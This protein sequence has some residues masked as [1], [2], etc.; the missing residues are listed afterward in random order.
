[1]WTL[2][3][4]TTLHILSVISCVRL[5]TTQLWINT[6]HLK[7][8]TQVYLF[9]WESTTVHPSKKIEQAIKKLVNL[10][11]QYLPQNARTYFARL[12]KNAGSYTQSFTVI[13]MTNFWICFYV[14]CDVSL[15][16]TGP[17]LL[18]NVFYSEHICSY[19]LWQPIGL[20]TPNQISLDAVRVVL[21]WARSH[22]GQLS[23]H[24]S[25]GIQ[26]SLCGSYDGWCRKHSNG[27][28][29]CHSTSAGH[30]WDFTVF[31]LVDCVAPQKG[32]N[33]MVHLPWWR[34]IL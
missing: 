13:C 16:W 8:Q 32:T 3:I 24:R 17:F 9:F 5:V 15:F 1:M 6:V 31:A 19:H 29:C 12:K 23:L 30:A 34:W 2:V 22:R 10:N 27:L 25:T 14:R 28:L 7:D 33:C 11:C 18:G 4:E 26:V 20:Q 21:V